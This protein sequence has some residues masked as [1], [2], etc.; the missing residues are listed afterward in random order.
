MAT[1]S[2]T[3]DMRFKSH[4][5]RERM[6]KIVRLIDDSAHGMTF[7]EILQ[8]AKMHTRTL[9][10]YF[11]YMHKDARMIHICGWILP[12]EGRALKVYK[13]GDLPDAPRP[14]IHDGE[15]CFLRQHPLHVP[16]KPAND[17]LLPV[18]CVATHIKPHS[19][20]MIDLFFGRVA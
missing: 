15:T 7:D 1:V 17:G 2:N 4:L 18:R 11:S 19:D 20:P 5:T 12:R 13:S 9:Q 3:T 16:R 6:N 10:E 14:R 8:R